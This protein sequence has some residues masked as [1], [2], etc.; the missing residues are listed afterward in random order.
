MRKIFDKIDDVFADTAERKTEAAT[1]RTSGT[2]RSPTSSANVFRGACQK[3]S[4]AFVGEGYKYARSGPHLTRNSASFVYRISFQSSHNNI[5]GQ[6]VALWM[7]ANVRSPLLKKWRGEQLNPY[8]KDDW[9]AGGMVHLL[10][11]IHA[12]IEWELG[13]EETRSAVVEDAIHFIRSDVF[14][15]FQRF[16]DP[17]AVIAELCQKEIG[18]FQIA[19]SV[20]FA[21][22]FGSREQ[23]QTILNRFIAQRKDL[24]DQIESATLNFRKEGFPACYSAAYADQ[25]AWVR[26]AYNL[27]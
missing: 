5:P 20:E 1:A 19:S 22:C 12:M 27:K 14:A 21:L 26:T 16:N 8:R 24:H 15:Y 6:H 2:L 17:G 9:V 7:H 23:A 10:N 4:E 11:R 13:H 3:I 25:V 18:A